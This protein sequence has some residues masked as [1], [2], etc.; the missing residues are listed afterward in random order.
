[1]PP[2]DIYY[3]RPRA[4]LRGPVKPRFEKLSLYLRLLD[5][6]EERISEEEIDGALY[7]N[8]SGEQ[9][10]DTKRKNF[11]AALNCQVNYLRLALHS[12]RSL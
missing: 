4:G 6:H 11:D 5:F 2:G 7:P 3:G 9:L 12:P 10:R 8:L 1:M